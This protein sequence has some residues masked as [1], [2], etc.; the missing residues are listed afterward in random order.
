M[1]ERDHGHRGLVDT[2]IL[3]LSD[4]LDRAQLP[5]HTAI[6]AVTLAELAAGPGYVT[7]TD[8]QSVRERSRRIETWQ[9]AERAYVP[10]PF[11]DTAARMYGQMCSLVTAVGRSPRARTADLMIA[12]TAAVE[13]IALYTTNPNDFRGLEELVQV[14]AVTRPRT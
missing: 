1:T 5:S 13:Q 2:N 8:L 11:D 6:S 4:Q 9:R 10:I 12:A 7:G 14:V 3:I